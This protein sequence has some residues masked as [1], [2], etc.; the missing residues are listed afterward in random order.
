M[1]SLGLA[2]GNLFDLGNKIVEK[3]FL[4]VKVVEVLLFK[5]L[6]FFVYF[7][8]VVVMLVMMMIFG[9]FSGDCEIIV[10]CSC[11]VSLYC[12]I[13]LVVVLSLLV[14]GWVFVLIEWV[15]LV[16]NY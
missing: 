5:V 12:L 9:C 4:V 10:I 7:L 1:V 3:N 6:E 14:M 11:G 16:V 15:V 2:I 8:F 13:L